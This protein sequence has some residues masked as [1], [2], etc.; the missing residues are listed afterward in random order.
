MGMKKL[1][2]KDFEGDKVKIKGPL[3]V[4]F[5]AEWCPFCMEF[6]PYFEALNPKGFELALADLSN[7]ANP[8]WDDFRIEVVPTLIA[9]KNGKAIWRKDGVLSQG[10]RKEDLEEMRR[11][12]HR[13]NYP[14][15]HYQ[16]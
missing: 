8:L 5:Y 10:L 12:L 1:G 2:P 11:V 14:N 13:K 9:F 6:K 7:E 15:H 4:L 3:G 16:V